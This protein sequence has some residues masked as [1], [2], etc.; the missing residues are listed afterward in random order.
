MHYHDSSRKQGSKEARQQG[1]QTETSRSQ[2]T[3]VLYLSCL[4]VNLARYKV[5]CR[6]DHTSL[7]SAETVVPSR[8]A[9]IALAFTSVA[10]TT[11]VRPLVSGPDNVFLFQR[12]RVA[13]IRLA[14]H[15]LNN[16]LRPGPR[17]K[18]EGDVAG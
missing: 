4:S 12:I 1:K 14:L 8:F 18:V 6:S 10:P 5:V 13:V 15:I 7:D 3:L 11:V 9:Q 2:R 17:Q 16:T